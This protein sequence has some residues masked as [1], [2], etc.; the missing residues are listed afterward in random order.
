MRVETMVSMLTASLSWLPGANAESFERFPMIAD[1]HAVSPQSRPSPIPSE[2][3]MISKIHLIKF[4]T[5]I[6]DIVNNLVYI[7]AH[8]SLLEHSFCS[9]EN[10]K[11]TFGGQ[12][13][14]WISRGEELE[15]AR[16]SPVSYL[17]LTRNNSGLG[18]DLVFKYQT[19]DQARSAGPIFSSA[20]LEVGHDSNFKVSDV[21]RLMGKQYSLIDKYEHPNSEYSEPMYPSTSKYGNKLILYRIDH[22]GIESSIYFSV[23]A[24]GIIFSIKLTQEVR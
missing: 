24:D 16:V 9:D 22:R 11:A 14:K 2:K 21:E 15:L 5:E 3:I 17:K 8:G 6:K 1:N 10:L 7:G 12:A 20:V 23:D 18:V 13:I 19:T 4:P